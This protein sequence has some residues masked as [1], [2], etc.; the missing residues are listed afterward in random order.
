MGDP[1]T[2]EGKVGTPGRR[3]EISSVLGDSIL[4][5]SVLQSETVVRIWVNDPK[6]PDRV[7]VGVE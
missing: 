2:F 7:I 3:L 4:M 1:P 5:T 6:E